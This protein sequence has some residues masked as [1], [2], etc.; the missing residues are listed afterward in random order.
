MDYTFSEEHEM[1]RELA[2][3]FA[4]KEVRPLAESND[5]NSE[6]PRE[7]V[8]KS[9]ELGF[10][11]IPFPEEYGGGGMGE[12]GYCVMLE[13]IARACFSTAVVIGGH[14]SIG[15]M[16]VYL[17]GTEEQKKKAAT[18]YVHGRKAGIVCIN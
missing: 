6:V 9:A 4:D 18:V 2:R 13:E 7:L 16:A 10:L 11:G 17:G 15:A 3:K 5:K 8:D 14:V 12:V 1:V